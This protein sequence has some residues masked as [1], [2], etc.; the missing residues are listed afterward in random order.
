MKRVLTYFLLGLTTILLYSCESEPQDQVPE[1]LI[2]SATYQNVLLEMQLVEAHINEVRVNQVYIRDSVNHFYSEIFD[3]HD[4]TMEDYNATTEYYAKHPTELK[5]IYDNILVE[6]STREAALQ[7]VKVDQ[8][9]ISPA[10]KHVVTEIILQTPIAELII[11]DSTNNATLI[12]DTLFRYVLVHQEVLDSFHIN[13]PSF[14]QS[15]NNISHNAKLYEG[16]KLD[17][18]NKTEKLKAVD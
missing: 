4:I 16:M 1:N 12:K 5:A 13:L 3:R 9:I 8:V 10:G 7:D 11:N 14:Q 6:L 15:Y 17:L 18:I 2:D